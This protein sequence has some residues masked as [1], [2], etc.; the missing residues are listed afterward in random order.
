[1]AFTFATL[2]TRQGV[3][4]VGGS[5]GL[6]R[7]KEIQKSKC[8]KN[9]SAPPVK[10]PSQISI[11]KEII[12]PL[13]D[14]YFQ[15][16]FWHPL[17]ALSCESDKQ[18]VLLP[19]VRSSPAFSKTSVSK[20]DSWEPKPHSSGRKP[21]AGSAGRHAS[22]RQNCLIVEVLLRGIAWIELATLPWWLLGTQARLEDEKRDLD[23]ALGTQTKDNSSAEQVLY[24]FMC[25]SQKGKGKISFMLSP[26]PCTF[27]HTLFLDVTQWKEGQRNSH[28]GRFNPWS[29]AIV[30]PLL[31]AGGGP[32]LA[33]PA[34][35]TGKRA[36]ESDGLLSAGEKKGCCRE[37]TL[38]LET[39]ATL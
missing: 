26:T 28:N 25:L 24:Y 23:R 37:I 36:D 18:T 33:P 7:K 2:L 9:I 12:Q 1:M 35:T 32:T 8:G 31:Y 4:R 16:D 29:A 30:P 21:R 17:G 3:G 27:Q 15:G 13:K 34:K 11:R 10:I 19:H 20:C 39:F 22:R 38:V 6:T 5:R 14:R